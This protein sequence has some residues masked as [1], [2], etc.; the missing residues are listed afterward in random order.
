M[1]DRILNKIKQTQHK[2]EQLLKV[3][4]DEGEILQQSPRWM[5]FTTWGLMA[6]AGVSLT[7]L[8]FAKTE[9][10]VM[11][12]GVLEPIAG[13]RDIQIPL[14]GVVDTLNVEEGER[15]KKGQLLL[16]LDPE[17]TRQKEKSAKRSLELIKEQLKYKEIELEKFIELNKA[18][19]ESLGRNLKFSQKIEE[20]Y[21]QLAVEGAITELQLLEQR[22]RVEEIRGKLGKSK[23]D[24]L[25]QSAILNQQIQQLLSQQA[26]LESQITELN[27]ALRY[28]KITSPVDGVVF[29]LMPGGAGYVN[30][31]NQPVLKV[32]P[33]DQLLARVE[34]PST[35]IGFVRVGQPVDISIDSFPATDFGVLEGSV[36]KVGSDALEPEQLNQKYRYPAEIELDNQQLMLKSGQ[37][38]PLQVGMSLTA[39]IKLRTVSYL[40]LLLGTF[41]NKT[42]SLRQINQG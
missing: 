29:E 3:G 26:G 21:I 23:V 4:S 38:L 2:L 32:V 15:V 16:T 37:T 42:D 31:G 20:R 10:I 13:V 6:T 40:Q 14:N 12:K 35:D 41:R 5:R 18:D 8:S 33:F 7:W 11:A 30:Q 17:A 22:N 1:K 28:Q 34:I 9:E 19:Q 36:I 27:V 39:S 25:R 24:G